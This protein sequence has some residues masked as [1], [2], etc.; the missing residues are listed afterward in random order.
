MRSQ[1]TILKQGA[2]EEIYLNRE[3]TYTNHRPPLPDICPRCQGPLA[4]HHAGSFSFA[5]RQALVCVF[6]D[7]A[8]LWF[9]PPC[10]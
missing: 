3:D 5:R 8:W 1:E 4:Y 2:R 10:I 9:E 6:C 7:V